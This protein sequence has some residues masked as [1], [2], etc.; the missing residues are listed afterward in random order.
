VQRQVM[1]P[2][3]HLVCKG[4]GLA[5]CIPA[6]ALIGPLCRLHSLGPHTQGLSNPRRLKSAKPYCIVP[7]GLRASAP[8]LH[9]P[10][11]ATLLME[12]TGRTPSAPGPPRLLTLGR[13]PRHRPRRLGCWT[14]DVAFSLTGAEPGPIVAGAEATACG[15]AERYAGANRARIPVQNRPSVRLLSPAFGTPRGVAVQDD[16]GRSLDQGAVR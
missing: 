3:P 1:Q 16:V 15:Q 11:S 2:H 4:R 12:Q 7:V 10:A 14:T 9:G 6:V 5:E 8:S 13:S